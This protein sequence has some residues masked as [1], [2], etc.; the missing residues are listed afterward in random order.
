MD[1]KQVF[2]DVEKKLYEYLVNLSNL[3][4]KEM[5]KD[6][7]VLIKTKIDSTVLDNQ[8]STA[9]MF[10]KS[11]SNFFASGWKMLDD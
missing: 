4:K 8:I 5:G 11:E 2:V 7:N 1:R 3:Y 9:G 6:Y 10:M